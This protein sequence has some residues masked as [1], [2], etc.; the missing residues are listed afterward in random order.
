MLFSSAAR[1]G[2]IP[3]CAAPRDP[4]WLSGRRPGRINSRASW[5]RSRFTVASPYWP[6][7][8][9]I[10]PDAIR[11]GFSRMRE[12]MSIRSRGLRLAAVPL[13][14][15]WLAPARAV[16]PAPPPD[17]AAKELEL[18]GVQTNLKAT[19]AEQRKIEADVEAIKLDR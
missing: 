1:M 16:E 2:S 12:R 7:I 5:R 3:S 4:V 18:K 13:M 14:G 15:L 19:E 9:I 8:P 10:G 11:A 6:D 17:R